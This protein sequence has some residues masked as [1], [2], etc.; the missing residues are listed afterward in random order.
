MVLRVSELPNGA[1]EAAKV[2]GFTPDRA[3][4]GLQIPLGSI[5]FGQSRDVVVS[6]P[7]TFPLESVS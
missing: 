1:V 7:L 5:C 6:V 2:L 3:S 4:W